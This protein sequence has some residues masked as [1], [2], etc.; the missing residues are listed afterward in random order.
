[1]LQPNSRVTLTNKGIQFYEQDILFDDY[2][3]TGD[4][5]IALTLEYTFPGFSIGLTNS[6]GFNLQ[7]KEEIILFKLG[8]G[9]VEVIFSNKDSQK[10]LATFPSSFST[11]NMFNNLIYY[12]EK[13]NNEFTLTLKGEKDGKLESEKVCSFKSPIEFETYNMIYYS[14]KNNVIKNINIAS[15]IPY[16]WVTNMQNTNGGYIWFY[17]D[18][19]EFKHCNGEAEIEQPDIYLNY[20]KYY[21]KYETEGDCDI[22]P[23][24]FQSEDTRLLDKRKNILNID[25][26]FT[27][28]YSQKIS[29]KFE[30]TKGKI[31]NICI[32]TDKNNDYYR[33]S[34]DKGDS[35]DIKGS[36]I[37]FLL[38][39]IKSI[40]W[41][42]N[43][44]HAPG[45]DHTNPLEYSIVKTGDISYGLFDLNLATNVKYIYE[46]KDNK[47]IIKNLNNY[48]VKEIKINNNSLI[49]NKNIN[50]TITDL[51]IEDL[52]G[53]T[54]NVV[55][56]NTIKKSVPG[57]IYSPIIVVDE[58]EQPLDL[59]A[60]YRIY[61]KNNKD[62]YWFTNVERE[63]F[64]PAHLI[65]LTNAP[66]PKN[67]T[68]VVYGIRENSFLNMD[69]IL[70]IPKEGLDTIDACANYYDI[71]FEK[72]LRYINKE[73]REIRLNDI[74]NYKLI[75][76]D[77]LKEDSYSINY[78]HELNS[79]EV[80]ISIQEDKKIKL[81]YNNI[82]E[83]IDGITYI[84]EYKYVNT[85]TIPSEDCYI[86]IGR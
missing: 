3:Y 13:R 32:T 48:I 83:N 20:G 53:N 18:A 55:I 17:R 73:Y 38:N 31:K 62:Y 44:K 33:T 9:Y 65:R 11:V 67:G 76:V 37:S 71:L 68:I 51:V 60:S 72:D 63:Y 70:R 64:K 4:F 46:Y 58:N 1:M 28:D 85:K 77:Y 43:V 78:R 26:S 66:S 5:N 40:K 30:G 47:L 81:L 80:D 6:E 24:I 19:F 57:T 35:I 12:L 56:E 84:N 45:S 74:K 27:L 82:S 50:A 49:I 79:Y 10:T 59:S 52:N 39:K 61:K 14:N 69:N 75:I 23:Y 2:I 25:K 21:L 22:I 42:C 41:I 7:D 8:Q 15:S 36:E 16:G 34:P 29:L 54:T 86:V